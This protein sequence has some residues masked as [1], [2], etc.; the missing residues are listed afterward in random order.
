[1]NFKGDRGEDEVTL[2]VTKG[3]KTQRCKTLSKKKGRAFWKNLEK[4]K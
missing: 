3:N 2:D 4:W 1:M